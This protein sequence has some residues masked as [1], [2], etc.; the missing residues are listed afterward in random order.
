MSVVSGPDFDELKRFNLAEIGMPPASAADD[1]DEKIEKTVKTEDKISA[2][3]DVVI[4]A[5]G[6]VTGN[7]AEQ[8][9]PTA[10]T[11]DVTVGLGNEA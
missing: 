5:D 7:E 8:S 3:S 2:T 9:V 6:E 4:M 1:G 10:A 11:H